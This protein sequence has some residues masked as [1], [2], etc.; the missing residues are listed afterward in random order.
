MN[1]SWSNTSPIESPQ[2]PRLKA[3]R[4]LHARKHREETRLFLLETT[5]LVQEALK[6]NWKL[7]GIYATESWSQKYP[8][9]PV[10]LVADRAFKDLTTLESPEGVV[11]I[12][13]Y[14]EDRP[15]QA[16]QLAL[17][18]V[19]I[20]DPGNLGTLIRTADA[21]GVDTVYYCR[22]TVDPYSPKAI[23]ATMG[24]IFHLPVLRA[25]LTELTQGLKDR[26][27]KVLATALGGRSLYQQSLKEPVAW[28]MGAE[29]LGLSE[30]EKALADEL[31]EIPILGQAE[32]LNVAA[33]TAV[34]LYETVRQRL[35]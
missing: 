11:A 30:E 2:N 4:A 5:K 31:V 28:M 33:A 24:S 23:R 21:A 16:S 35:G 12:A 25:D 9:I 29:G 3:V 26:G 20:Q 14:P 6:A 13:H 17:I 10:T 1:S 19:G 15:V 34:C 22:G 18:A 7:E 27:V 8:E 32:S